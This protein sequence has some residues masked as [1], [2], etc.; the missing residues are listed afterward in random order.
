MRHF[1]MY[2]WIK[3]YVYVFICL[4]IVDVFYCHSKPCI[5]PRCLATKN[6]T[7][8]TTILLAHGNKIT[9]V[10]IVYIP[11]VLL[12]QHEIKPVVVTLPYVKSVNL[13]NFGFCSKLYE[14]G[15]KWSY[16]HLFSHIYIIYVF[17]FIFFFLQ[18]F[19]FHK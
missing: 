10:R 18:G 17:Y 13:C 11:T 3:W 8:L 9:A 16:F 14:S 5:K 15:W 6:I 19:V 12:L 4:W 2:V 7:S 1:H